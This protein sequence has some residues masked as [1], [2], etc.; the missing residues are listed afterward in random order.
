ML[1][2]SFSMKGMHAQALA[3]NDSAPYW[4]PT[5]RPILLAKAGKRALAIKAYDQVRSIMS[6]VSKAEFYATLGDKESA[7]EWLQRAYREPS[8]EL[9][10]IRGD[11]FLD[12]LRD[13]PRFGE[14]LKAMHLRE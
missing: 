7:I 3:Q 5:N 9:M 6:P 12:N 14:L 11:A 8:G 4:G 10:L 13:D 1:A 2:A